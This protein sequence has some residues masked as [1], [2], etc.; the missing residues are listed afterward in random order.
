MN[1]KEKRIYEEYWFKKLSG[2]LPKL[3]LPLSGGINGNRDGNREGERNR[4]QLDIPAAI[5]SD[6][7]KVCKNSDIALFILFFSGLNIVLNRYTGIEDLVVGTMCPGNGNG[8]EGILFCRN[9][10]PGGA[11]FKEFIAVTRQTVLEM[12]NYREYP[13]ED[14]YEKLLMKRGEE[15]L[16]IFN[17]AF[18]YDGFQGVSRTMSRFDVLLLLRERGSGADLSLMLEYNSTLYSSGVVRRFT[19][20]VVNV[21]QSISGKLDRKIED[22]EILSAEEKVEILSALNDSTGD[23]PKDKTLQALFEEQAERR[24]D[25]IALIYGAKKLTYSELNQRANRL[26]RLLRQKGV[27]PGTPV[28][29][30]FDRSF[31]MITAILGILKSGGVYLPIDPQAPEKRIV[32]MLDDCQVPLVL[33]DAGVKDLSF[34]TLQGIR[35]I[36]TQPYLT[37]PRPAIADLDRLPMPDRSLVNYEKYSKYIGLT[38]AKN[39]ISLFATRGCPYNCVYCHKIWPKRHVYRSAENI[40][41]E[42]EF[43]YHMGVRRFSFVDDI[44]NLDVKNSSRFYNL[45]IEK[46]LDVQFFYPAGVRTDILTRDY[47]D[48]MVEAGTVHTG[49]ALET[50]SP[51]LQRLIRKNLDLE[52]FRENAEYLCREYPQVIIDL[53]TM[54]G[55]PT[56]SEEEAMMTLDFIKSLKW[57]HFPFV[58][59]LKIYQNTDMEKLALRSGI[60]REA[61]VS[62]ENLAFQELPATL[63]FD[64]QFSSKYQ[65]DF[66]SGYFLLKERLLHVLPYQMKR[67]TEDEIVQKYDSYLPV[68]IDGFDHLLQFLGITREELTVKECLGEESISIPGWNKKLREAF[69]FTAKKPGDNALRVILLDLSQLF[70]KESE[71]FYDVVEPPL[72]L[73]YLLTYLNEQFAEKI[74]GRIAKSRVDFDSYDDLKSMLDE[75]KPHVIGARTLTY[76]K[77]FFHRTIALIRQWGFAGPIVAGGPYATS[78][79]KMILQDG[80]VDVAVMGEGEVTFKK[81]IERIGEH[82]GQLPPEDVLKGIEG[83]AFIPGR[84][85]GQNRLARQGIVLDEKNRFLSGESG[86]NVAQVNRPSD[87]AYIIYTSGTTGKPKGV[88]IEH[89]NVVSLMCS[90]RNRFDFNNRDVWTMFH[91][92]CF[93]FSVW[94]IF[95][96]LLHGGKLV[97][98]P[99]LTAMEP[100]RFLQVLKKEAVTVLNQ[101]PTVFYQLS[102]EEL[103]QLGRGLHLRYIIF[104]GEALSPARLKEWAAQYPGTRLINMFGITETT[105]HVTYKHLGNEDIASGRSNIGQPLP[106]L[107]TYVMESNRNLSPLEVAGELCVGGEGVGRGYVNS[108]PLTH[109]KFVENPYRPGEILYRSGDLVRL[110]LRGELE[111]L[112][113]IDHQVKIRGFRIELAEIEGH[114]S[115]YPGVKGAVVLD[116]GADGHDPPA[117]AEKYLCAYIVF[118]PLSSPDFEVS[119]LRAYLSRELPDY[120]V[121]AYFVPLK[122]LPLTANGKLDR[123]ALPDPLE[124]LVSGRAHQ[125]RPRNKIEE[126]L[127]EI[128]QTVLNIET[129]GVRD[130]FFELGGHSLKATR[131]LSRIHSELNVR[132]ELKTVFQHSTIEELALAVAGLK[133]EAYESIRAVETKEYYDLSHAQR[134][135]WILDKFEEEQLAYNLPVS[136]VFAGPLDRRAFERTFES[137]IERHESLRTTFLVK[138]GEPRQRVNDM[139]SQVFKVEYSD[140]RD[141]PDKE[142][143]AAEVTGKEAM[144]P[145]DL[146]EGP[147]IRT[148]LLQ[149]EEQKYIFLFTMHHIVSDGWSMGVA[150]DELFTLYN[151]YKSGKENPLLPLRLQYRDYASWQ[152]E[153]LSGQQLQ[154]HESYWKS[155]FEGE[156]PLLALFTDYPRPASKSFKGDYHGS[157]FKKSLTGRIKELGR[158]MGVSLFMTLLALFKTLLYR[159]T[160]QSDIVVGSPVAGRD[161]KELENQI[162]FY[163]NTLALRTRFEGDEG[164]KE[165]L[166][167]VKGVTLGAFEHQ[168]YPFDRLVDQLRLKR[169]LS[170]SPLFDVFLVLQNPD[171]GNET[172]SPVAELAIQRYGADFKVSKFDLT[173]SFSEYE[174]YLTLSI[175]YNT[176]LFFPARIERMIRHFRGIVTAVLGNPHQPLNRLDYIPTEEKK[177]LFSRINGTAFAFPR[178]KTIHALFEEQVERSPHAAAVVSEDRLISYSQ[179]NQEAD[180]LA[181]YLAAHH[182]IRVADR[183]GFI[184]DRSERIVVTIL[185]VLKTGAAFVAMETGEARSRLAYVVEDS[186]C[187]ALLVDG[188]FEREKGDSPKKPRPKKPPAIINLD[189]KREIISGCR[190]KNIKSST[191]STDIAY[192][193]YTSGSTGRPKGIVAEHRQFNNFVEGFKSQYTLKGQWRFLLS[194]SITFD[195]SYRQIFLPLTIGAEL[196]ILTDFRSIKGLVGYMKERRIHFIAATPIVWWEI[197]E[198]VNLNGKPETLTFLS[199][200]GDVLSPHLANRL[201]EIFRDQIFVNMYGPTETCLVAMHYEIRQEHS[202][203]LPL[204]KAL[205]NYEVY[206]LD[207]SLCPVPRGVVGEICIAGE[208][209]SRGYQNNPRLTAEKFV[210]NPFADNGGKMYRTGDRGVYLDNGDIRFLG[211][212]DDQ[213]KIR[214]IRVEPGEVEGALLRLKYID[215]AAVI[216]GPNEGGDKVL[217]AYFVSRVPEAE[218]TVSK[219][220]EDL[221]G[222]LP[223]YMIPATFVRLEALPLTKSGKVDRAALRDFGGASLDSGVEYVP[224]RNKLEGKMVRIWQRVLGREKIGVLDNFF[225][226]GGDSITAVRVVYE[227]DRRLNITITLKDLFRFPTI[228][229]YTGYLTDENYRVNRLERASFYKINSRYRQGCT[230]ICFPPMTGFS[231]A[232]LKLRE[233]IRHPIYLFNMILE[234]LDGSPLDTSTALIKEF[235]KQID[236]IDKKGPVVLIGWSAGGRLAYEVCQA[237]ELAGTR[238][239]LVILIDVSKITPRVNPDFFVEKRLAFHRKRLKREG[240]TKAQ[241]VEN[242]D[243]MRRFF[244]YYLSVEHAGTINADIVM[245][246]SKLTIMSPNHKPGTP[247]LITEDTKN[248]IGTKYWKDMTTGEF[249]LY[250]GAGF[251]GNM[252]DDR[253]VEGNARIIKGIFDEL[254]ASG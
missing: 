121:P 169:D 128:W 106:A 250:T 220:R 100:P 135:L 218:L 229:E 171:K 137:F 67:L 193:V 115:R 185:A 10:V 126:K 129:V 3:T 8:S 205:P 90:R 216:A 4:F 104:G 44:F 68:N 130:N 54:H 42:V 29:M 47:I 131:I 144:S 76:F 70:S 245:I 214:G 167:R 110:G 163:L 175:N 108:P 140:L 24:P 102:A 212:Q 172:G 123:R 153:R 145:F 94:E 19:G 161:H 32:S 5:S 83:I 109:E 248:M 6:L 179:L 73:M 21:F 133:S 178:D 127:A 118:S 81:L 236:L 65:A 13:F 25:G 86:E 231:F 151:A 241:I 43:H 242:L 132:I 142:T 134:R 182:A 74:E 88:M 198:E 61:I 11:T 160:G 69:R 30:L 189:E 202:E 203:A 7:K 219:I 79:Y 87:L 170:R 41:K 55:F 114:L 254:E 16:D 124:S 224:P 48:L 234:S 177:M 211:R 111:Y 201:K 46:Q 28:G 139:D 246:A 92:Y 120:M 136:Y 71:A 233:V 209:V 62:S 53:F 59:V 173:F 103:R 80:N 141:Q 20:N 166:E 9:Q 91:S 244:Y 26:A 213:V 247:N 101:I 251:H 23:Y 107:R 99:R 168:V 195:A 228:A 156:I 240:N 93:D 181:G 226:I 63:P 207:P 196:H 56:E 17:F 64:K 38:L 164:F 18:I 98:V 72:G 147:L 165:L 208:G 146:A 50:A 150:V 191:A 122:R 149:T 217:S 152:K 77:D 157:I 97:L 222:Y 162:G 119:E 155:Q 183:V 243:R 39:N 117:G 112:G 252:F 34:T 37:S 249:R 204:G 188:D 31:Q 230:V 199:S 36:H 143:I 57:A 206:I 187:S 176:D 239:D 186:Q 158:D 148:R 215:R 96:A 58:F 235:V 45:I 190:H 82:K 2:E 89:R 78:A 14:L 105:V 232:Y 225:E 125:V 194:A 1:E 52:K 84:G 238:V 113:R 154:A 174:D 138:E 22:L 49:L 184:L 40:V 253:Y 200:S 192:V 221:A 12:L 197:L 85:Q 210:E 223:S 35:L 180:R 116:R 75:F 15:S 27:R 66:L 33:L 159:Y 51:R 95:G 60:S 237:L 227:I